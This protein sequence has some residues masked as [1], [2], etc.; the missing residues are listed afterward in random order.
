MQLNMGNKLMKTDRQLQKDVI[1]ELGWDPSVDAARVGVEVKDGIVTLS[2]SVD[3]YPQKW[4]AERAASRVAGTSGV[5]VDI[6]VDLPGSHKR[7][8][9][10]R[11]DGTERP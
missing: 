5:V 4:S 3:S 7:D 2:G 1:E 10:D 6:K 8:D 9:A 11:A